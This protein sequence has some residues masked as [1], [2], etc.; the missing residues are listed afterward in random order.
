MIVFCIYCMLQRK[1]G[2]EEKRIADKE[3]DDHQNELMEYRRK[4]AK[5]GFAVSS[6]SHYAPSKF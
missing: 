5:G 1:K 3:W 4:M 6:Q 2:R